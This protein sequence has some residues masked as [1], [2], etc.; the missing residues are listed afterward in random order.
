MAMRQ[1]E[2][3]DDFVEMVEYFYPIIV[4]DEDKITFEC[5]ATDE[6]KVQIMKANSRPIEVYADYDNPHIGHMAFTRANVDV[7]RT[8][9]GNPLFHRYTTMGDHLDTFFRFREGKTKWG[10]TKCQKR[11]GEPFTVFFENERRAWLFFKALE[12]RIGQED[13]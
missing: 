4:W 1:C 6:E 8:L 13:D 2:T 9:L 5:R 3:F 7:I 12:E 11:G 10:A